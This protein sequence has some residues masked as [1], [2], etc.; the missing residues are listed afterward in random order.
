VHDSKE[1]LVDG[2]LST[3][4][5]VAERDHLI[6]APRAKELGAGRFIS[7]GLHAPSLDAA[8]GYFQASNEPF[9]GRESALITLIAE[10]VYLA[11]AA[12]A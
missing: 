12:R 10:I 1:V 3:V 2:G 9:S 7:K 8:I 4:T 6:F 5:D 11:L